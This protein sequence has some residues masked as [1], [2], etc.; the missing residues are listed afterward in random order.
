[1]TICQNAVAVR[2]SSLRAVYPKGLRLD[3]PT[4]CVPE[5]SL[6]G[7]TG[8]IPER[9][10]VGSPTGYEPERSTDSM[11]LRAVYPKDPEIFG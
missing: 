10:L 5:R 1:M 3:G 8:F 4:G 6:M 2:L 11:G 9:S 7:L